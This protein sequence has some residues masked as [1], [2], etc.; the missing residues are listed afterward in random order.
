MGLYYY[1]SQSLVLVHK[2]FAMYE[3]KIYEVIRA[4]VTKLNHFY[5]ECYFFFEI[6]NIIIC[7]NIIHTLST[8]N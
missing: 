3:N 7:N 8:C 6:L 1:A 2:N 4:I 5:Y